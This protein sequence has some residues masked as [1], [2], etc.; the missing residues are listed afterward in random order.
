MAMPD[1]RPVLR[2][3]LCAALFPVAAVVPVHGQAPADSAAIRATALDY[4][5]GWY[6]GDAERMERALHPDLAKRIVNTDPRGRSMLGHQ[7]A[8]TLVQN[9][10]RGGGRDTPAGDQRTDVH[11]L[12][13]FGNTASVRVD[14]DTWIDYM[15]IVKWNGRWVIINVLWELRPR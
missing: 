8:L 7:S 14:A 6:A 15:H 5:E 11:I 4:I 2:S 3:A 13:I 9:T 12:D 1:L 10:R